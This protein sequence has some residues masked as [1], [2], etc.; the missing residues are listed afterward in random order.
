MCFRDFA[1]FW[2]VSRGCRTCG[3]FFPMIP[4]N[5]YNVH[6]IIQGKPKDRMAGGAE[7]FNAFFYSL[8]STDTQVSRPGAL[9]C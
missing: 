8:V 2:K 5:H 9:D 7:E 1:G 6:D 4:T 3:L